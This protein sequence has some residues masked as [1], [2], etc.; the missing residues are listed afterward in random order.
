MPVPGAHRAYEAA[1]ARLLGLQHENGAWEGEME[2]STMILSQYVIVLHILE[3]SPD[4]PTRQSILQCFRKA[5]TAEG[6]WG[7]HPQAPPSAYATTLAYVALRLLGTEPHDSLAAGARRW[8]HT[9]PGGAG[10]VPQWGFFWLAVLGL[11]PYRQVA[12]VPPR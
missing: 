9:Q 8:I 6:S 4:E 11:M 10:A 12:P 7:M 2:W 5:R 1:C 3:R